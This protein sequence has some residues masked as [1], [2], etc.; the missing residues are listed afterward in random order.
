MNNPTE[1]KPD[2]RAPTTGKR[3]PRAVA[4]AA[5]GIIIAVAE[6]GGSPERAFRALFTDEVMTW[7][8][9]P[10]IYHWKDY[11]AD[12]RVCGPWSVNVQLAD[13][14]VVSAHGEFCEIIEPSKL[15]M[16]R[17]FVGHPFLGSRETTITYRFEPSPHGTL[18]TV[19][20]EGFIG[21]SQAAYGNAEIWEKVL[22]WLDAYLSSK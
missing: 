9:M 8:K 1:K 11:Q 22:S 3:A 18:I 16:T 5:A 7:W 4:D 12:L 19:R 17:E 6:V 20:D 14:N 21:R 15:V 2:F 13:G 10:G